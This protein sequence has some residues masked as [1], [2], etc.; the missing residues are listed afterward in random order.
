MEKPNFGATGQFAESK[1]QPPFA[2]GNDERTYGAGNPTDRSHRSVQ[3]RTHRTPDL[4][5]IVNEGTV[6][7]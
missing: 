7:W 2:D 1:H 5:V 6:V 3:S 4:L